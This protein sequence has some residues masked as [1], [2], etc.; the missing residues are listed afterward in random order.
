MDAHET[1]APARGANDREVEALRS[2]AD[3]VDRGDE[4]LRGLSE[5]AL[6]ALRAFADAVD[7]FDPRVAEA[8]GECWKPLARARGRA[9][10]ALSEIERLR[11]VAPRQEPPAAERQAPPTTAD[12]PESV[13]KPDARAI[14]PRDRRSELQ[15]RRGVVAADDDAFFEAAVAT[16]LAYR[17]RNHES[18]L[19]NGSLGGIRMIVRNVGSLGGGADYDFLANVSDG[20]AARL[21]AAGFSH[22]FGLRIEG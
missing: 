17:E 4:R 8:L 13:A 7:A 1:Q 10:M 5:D 15:G 19:L 14:T 2:V 21:Q 20:M 6:A 11:P 16:E 3:T 22:L 9:A 18:V 12:R